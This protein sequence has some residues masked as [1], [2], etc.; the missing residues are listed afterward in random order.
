MTLT[1][2][3][4]PN[5]V[6]NPFA[7]LPKALAEFEQVP[8]LV[9]KMFLPYI[10]VI[11][12][13]HKYIEEKSSKRDVGGILHDVRRS[14]LGDEEG[15]EFYQKSNEGQEVTTLELRIDKGYNR[16][17]TVSVVSDSYNSEGER[18][19]RIQTEF[20]VR[21]GIYITQEVEPIPGLGKHTQKLVLSDFALVIA[22]LTWV[23]GRKGHA[24]LTIESNKETLDFD[25]TMETKD[26]TTG[27]RTFKTPHGTLVFPPSDEFIAEAIQKILRFQPI[28]LLE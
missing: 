13:D 10:N 21:R 27:Q 24:I 6:E 12:T 8:S 7:H 1:K 20:K 5:R 9:Q 18:V 19:E 28:R 2:G 25:S 26:L 3:E 17:Q 15:F 4:S 16:V 23:M 14:H 22:R 11:R